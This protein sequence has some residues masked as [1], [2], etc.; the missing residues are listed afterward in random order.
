MEYNITSFVSTLRELMYNSFP[1][2]EGRGKNP[3]DSPKHGKYNEEIR[4]VAFKV[5]QTQVLSD[6]MLVFDIGNEYSEQYYPYYHILEDAQVI[7]KRN[8]GTIESKGSQDKVKKL[9]QRDYGKVTF[10]NKMFSQEYRKIVNSEREKDSDTYPNI[11]YHY[12]ETMLDHIVKTLAVDFDIKYVGQ[13]DNGLMEEYTMERHTMP[14]DEMATIK[15]VL[16]M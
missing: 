1:Y 10:N 6:N 14:S 3:N 16:N 11:H 5:N 9:G 15:Q 13:S 7:H 12:I 4:D 2:L 8:K